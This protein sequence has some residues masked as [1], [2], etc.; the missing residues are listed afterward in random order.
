M[1]N[2][3]QI[4]PEY[5]LFR[6]YR[7]SSLLPNAKG[8]KYCFKGVSANSWLYPIGGK[9]DE[10]TYSDGPYDSTGTKAQSRHYERLRR[11][12]AVPEMHR[13][14]FDEN[15]IDKNEV[16]KGIQL[17]LRPDRMTSEPKPGKRVRE[18]KEN[19]LKSR[20]FLEPI[21]GNT[22]RPSTCPG[23]RSRPTVSQSQPCELVITSTGL[24]KPKDSNNIN[25]NKHDFY[26]E[27][28]HNASKFDNTEVEKAS[29]DE[30]IN[31]TPAEKEKIRPYYSRSEIVPSLFLKTRGAH[32]VTCDVLKPR[33]KEKAKFKRGPVLRSLL[34]K[35]SPMLKHSDGCPYKCKNCFKACLV[36]DDYYNKMKENR[37]V[38]QSK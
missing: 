24:N 8:E 36:S 9:R 30:P 19:S 16:L 3:C 32:S 27:Y 12:S 17:E 34:Q 7:V 25:S 15:G 35:S 26:K 33:E 13:N 11:H 10:L 31:S 14:R 6:V 37:S 18:N 28:E 38:V 29:L 22:V 1:S 2:D 20:S 23:F 5:R 4:L 21:D